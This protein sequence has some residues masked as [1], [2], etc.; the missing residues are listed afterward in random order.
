MFAL[1]PEL[2]GQIGCTTSTKNIKL[3][4]NLETLLKLQI[5]ILSSATV[6]QCDS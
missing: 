3:V 2:L 4:E 5:S 6:K 1:D